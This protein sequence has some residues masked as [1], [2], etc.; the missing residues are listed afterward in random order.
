VRVWFAFLG[1]AETQPR[2][3]KAG[4][5]AYRLWRERVAKTLSAA[6]RHGL[7]DDSIDVECEAAALIALVDGLAIQATFD[8]RAVS[9]KR[10]LEILDDRLGRLAIAS[11]R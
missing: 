8:P 2:L 11:A 9:A 7:V 3:A 5:D 10:Q 4:R 1:L 6:R